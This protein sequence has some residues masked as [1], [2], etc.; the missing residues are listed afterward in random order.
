MMLLTG[1]VVQPMG[2]AP[3][4]ARATVATVIAIRTANRIRIPLRTI[5]D[6]TP[7]KEYTM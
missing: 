7:W 2:L 4:P 1:S 6:N 5:L 3:P